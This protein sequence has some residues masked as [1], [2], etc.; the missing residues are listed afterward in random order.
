MI[1]GAIGPQEASFLFDTGAPISNL[2][3]GVAGAPE[4]ENVVKEVVLGRSR[5]ALEFRVKDL[6]VIRRSLG[7]IGVLGNNLLRGRTIYI[8]TASRII[9]LY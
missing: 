3:I 6:S 4:G 8:D 7:C 9:H 1:K 5:V 2:D